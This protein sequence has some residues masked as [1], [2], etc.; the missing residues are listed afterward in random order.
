M[1]DVLAFEK[2]PWRKV[3]PR[4]LAAA[5]PV[6]TMLHRDERQLYYWLTRD[7]AEGAG[8]VVD[9][10][11]YVG[12]S[13]AC[14]AEGAVAAERPL[15]IHAY[16]RFE[17]QNAERKA[18]L[19]K[20]GVP[21]FEGADILPAIR[22]ML[23]QWQDQITL[24]PGDIREMGWQGGPVELLIVDAAKHADTGDH[25][26][27]TWYPALIPGQSIVVHQDFLNVRQPWIAAQMT[28]FS[29]FFEPV[30]LVHRE[31]VVFRCIKAVTPRDV[32]TRRVVGMPDTAYVSAIRAMQPVA[33]AMGGQERFRRLLAV[34]ETHPDIRVSHKLAQ[35]LAR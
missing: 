25:I 27:R 18:R 9:L 7:Y 31:T 32:V 19:I 35:A 12:G 2:R 5:D 14:L 22:E 24:H 6:F 21:E 30:A 23:E 16:D 15:D 28:L 17:I 11:A 13:T 1:S 20:D 4:R 33:D 34:A 3:D 26:A 10:G 29:D 8:A